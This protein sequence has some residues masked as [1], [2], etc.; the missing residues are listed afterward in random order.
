MVVAARLRRS[1]DIDIVRTRGRAVRRPAF[2]LR[3][4]AGPAGVPRLAVSA[5]RTLGGAVIRNRARRRLREAFRKA[6]TSTAALDVVVVARREAV[7]APF[8]AL[9]S[10]ARAALAEAGW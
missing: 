7:D 8:G 1:T 3:A 4:L 5:P 10:E 6:F 2:A 9:V